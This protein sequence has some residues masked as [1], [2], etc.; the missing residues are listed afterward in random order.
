MGERF[1][2]YHNREYQIKLKNDLEGLEVR[3]LR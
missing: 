3:K 2:D 1:S